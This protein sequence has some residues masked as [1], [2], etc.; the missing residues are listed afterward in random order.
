MSLNWT[1]KELLQYKDEGFSID[2]KVNLP[3]VT[4]RDP[5]VRKLTPVHVK[6]FVE[7]NPA[8]L[9]F[10]L[11]VSGEMT[12]PCAITLQDVLYPFN[13]RTAE[14]YPLK[15]EKDLEIEDTPVEVIHS[16][17]GDDIDLNAA[18]TEAILVEKPM[19][20]ISEEAMKDARL[21][22]QG[23]AMITEQEKKEQVDPRLEKLKK[24]FDE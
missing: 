23:W 8:Y 6:G 18:L 15:D 4:S 21:E 11:T 10:H 17:E 2:E 12:L 22:G 20:V 14:T 13:I 24:F 19:R 7:F 5:E 3:D 1:V 16:V 9:T